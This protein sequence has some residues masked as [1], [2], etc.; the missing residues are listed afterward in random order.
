MDTTVSAQPTREPVVVG[1]RFSS[2]GKIYHFDATRFSSLH[3]GDW[4]VVT[5]SRGRQIGQVAAFDPPN[6]ENG[7]SLKPIDRVAS[8]RDLAVKHYWDSKSPE[9]LVIA[10]EKAK[11]LGIPVKIVKADYT[12]DGS[13]LSFQYTADDEKPELGRL[14]E[15]IQRAFKPKVDLRLI[16]PRDAAK[17]IGG[18]GACGLD[19]RCCSMFL[20]EFSPISIKMAKEQGISLNPSEITGM[21][22]RLRCCLVYEYE[23]YVEARKK[24]PKR[25]KDVG[26]PFGVGRVIDL[27]PLK[28]SAVVLVGEMQHV[29]HRDDIQPLAELH[30][31]EEKAASPCGLNPG[32]TC[33]H[34]RKRRRKNRSADEHRDASQPAGP[35]E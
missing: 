23:Q 9:A 3:A 18:G 33:K 24:L 2:V 4:V 12:F 14:L 1:V 15:D 5:T 34:A 26:T 29:V 19:T 27:L 21:C 7:D 16:G 25:N 20:T 6:A 31:M 32:C 8:N 35:A 17:I 28:D 11:E 13:R 30:A 10:R 22:G